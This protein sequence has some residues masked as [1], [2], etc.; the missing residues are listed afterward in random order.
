MGIFAGTGAAF[1]A[2]MIPGRTLSTDETWTPAGNPYLISGDIIIPSCR[3][4]T[5]TAGT[6]VQLLLS[7]K[8]HTTI[9]NGFVSFVV[10]GQIVVD[11]TPVSP[12][13]FEPGPGTSSYPNPWHGLYFKSGATGSRIQY[14]QLNQPVIGMTFENASPTNA[15]IRSRIWHA[16]TGVQSG[17]GTLVLDG[18][19]VDGAFTG[20]EMARGHL[21]NCVLIGNGDGVG[22]ELEQVDTMRSRLTNV[23]IQNFAVG[24]NLYYGTVTMTN[25]IV[26][27]ETPINTNAWVTLNLSNND[28]YPPTDA[29]CLKCMSVDPLYVAERD[30]HLE[31][32]SPCIDAA[33][34]AESPDHD[35]DGTKRPLGGGWDVGAYERA[36]SGDAGVGGAG[37]DMNEPGLDG[38]AMCVAPSDLSVP[39]QLDM[40]MPDMAAADLG[41]V[42]PRDFATEPL[43]LSRAASA[44]PPAWK[45]LPDAGCT[46]AVAAGR[47]GPP[48]VPSAILLAA[49]ALA[50]LRRRL[51]VRNVARAFVS[52]V[53]FLGGCAEN[54]TTATD[55]AAAPFDFAVPTLPLLRDFS[56]APSVSDF[57]TSTM[58]DAAE[59]PLTSAPCLTGGS[60]VYAEVDNG[61]PVLGTYTEY[62]PFWDPIGTGPMPNVFA[63]QSRGIGSRVQ[64]GLTA[65]GNQPLVPGRY[66]GASDPQKTGGWL[67]F[68]GPGSECLGLYSH[69]WFQIESIAGNVNGSHTELTAIFEKR[70]DD[71]SG[72]TRGC[73][74]F[75]QTFDSADGGL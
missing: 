44:P 39:P 47:G 74:H 49:V 20:V 1:A 7:D 62:P 11:G 50:Q 31:P 58:P 75:E 48:L 51:R 23:S 70:C 73:V 33:N 32:T 57:S 29:P 67:M 22:V 18:V 21:I 28:I 65:A 40:S 6:D 56:V 3:K 27:C 2:T 16:A 42:L 15:I 34:A 14:A 45:P 10:S 30:L 26:T 35:A 61:T 64:I 69:G 41:V 63:Y 54:A 37:L 38:G 8:D 36:P 4:L 71:G 24:L 17:L 12:V 46:C 43:D 5:I 72:I 25:S 19:V 68:H 53:L 66:D 55:G 59:P 60:V 13:V 52:A 9:D